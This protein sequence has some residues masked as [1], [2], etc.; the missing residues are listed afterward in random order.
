MIYNGSFLGFIFITDNSPL[1]PNL[2][3]GTIWVFSRQGNWEDGEIEFLGNSYL[4][5]IFPED[6]SDHQINYNLIERTDASVYTNITI[7]QY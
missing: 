3:I 5:D 6:F 1:I 4:T 7:N 2:R